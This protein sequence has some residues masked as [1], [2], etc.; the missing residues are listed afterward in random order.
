MGEYTERKM[1]DEVQE[2]QREYRVE[3]AVP[4]RLSKITFGVSR[5][6]KRQTKYSIRCGQAGEA[7]SLLG[8]MR[9]DTKGRL[10]LTLVDDNPLVDDPGAMRV[11]FEVKSVR[12]AVMAALLH[13]GS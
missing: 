1:I 8:Y 3:G 6:G 2:V 5:T 13:N 9:V 12:A 10:V 4:V 7:A 11:P